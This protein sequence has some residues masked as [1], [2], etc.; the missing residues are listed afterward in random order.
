MR[1][2][3]PILQH[4]L[5]RAL[6]FSR[7]PPPGTRSTHLRGRPTEREPLFHCAKAP[8]CVAEIR[9]GEPLRLGIPRQAQQVGCNASHLQCIAA[10][11]RAKKCGNLTAEPPGGTVL[12]RATLADRS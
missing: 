9:P 3:D 2:R 12:R 8:V 10:V 1:L 4:Q 7:D 5:T 6:D 11:V